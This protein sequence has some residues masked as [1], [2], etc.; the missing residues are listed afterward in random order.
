LNLIIAEKFPDL[1]LG[2]T[3]NDRLHR[4]SK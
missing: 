1:G 4:A 2:K 3:I